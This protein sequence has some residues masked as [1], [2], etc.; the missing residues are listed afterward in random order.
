MDAAAVAA[1]QTKKP[2]SVLTLLPQ[3]GALPAKGNSG[4]LR[5][6]NTKTKKG[7][8]GKDERFLIDLFAVNTK[9]HQ[10]GGL[11]VVVAA[12]SARLHIP[13]PPEPWARAKKKKDAHS[14]RPPQN[15]IRS[16]GCRCSIFYC[17]ETRSVSHAWKTA[18]S[19]LLLHEE[20][21]G[22]MYSLLPSPALMTCP[23]RSGVLLQS[24]TSHS[25]AFFSFFFSQK[26]NQLS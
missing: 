2:F 8:E 23:P 17:T 9:L 26:S 24:S 21:I 5:A 15:C 22:R 19:G 7:I 11:C 20:H 1:A 14:L 18:S 3:S 13:R 4:A 25:V 16:P 10:R 12:R 6:Q